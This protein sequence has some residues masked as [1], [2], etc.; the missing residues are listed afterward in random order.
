MPQSLNCSLSI[1]FNLSLQI[2]TN[3]RV[4]IFAISK[5]SGLLSKQLVWSV[6]WSVNSTDIH[7]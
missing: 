1:S 4:G 5:W 6:V 7:K 2:D 3:S